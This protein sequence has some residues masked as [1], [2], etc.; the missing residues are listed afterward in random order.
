MHTKHAHLLTPPAS[1]SQQIYNDDAVA[2]DW[3]TEL[4]FKGVKGM[5]KID[6]AALL[7][8]FFLARIGGRAEFF[9]SDDPSPRSIHA[10]AAASPR[11]VSV[12]YQRRS[13][14]V[15]ATRLRAISTS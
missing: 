3:I 14:G 2:P 5:E 10:V 12:E 1:L 13:R 11:L 9:L 15:A 7:D 4:A 8:W 6:H